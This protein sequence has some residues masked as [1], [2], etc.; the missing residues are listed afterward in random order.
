MKETAFF[1]RF[2]GLEAETQGES[3]VRR[4]G[5]LGS[6]VIRDPKMLRRQKLKRLDAGDGHDM[7]LVGSV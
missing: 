7:S 1:T 5:D 4:S 6:V 2:G 3:V